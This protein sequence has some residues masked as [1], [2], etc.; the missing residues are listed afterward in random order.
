M[1]DLGAYRRDHADCSGPLMRSWEQLSEV[2]PGSP[3][4]RYF[5]R[6]E[7]ACRHCGECLLDPVALQ[8]LDELRYRA[9]F[10]LRV[11]SGYRCPVHNERVGGAKHS[12]HTKG[13]AFDLWL[14]R[15][16]QRTFVAFLAAR[17]GFTGIGVYR[18]FLHLDVG[19]S[20]FWS[21]TDVGERE[22]GP[23]PPADLEH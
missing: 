6:E 7:L 20:R 18:H 9:G 3:P 1:R 22:P 23:P 2:R 12:Y 15:D 10:P 19:P 5:R 17:V 4:A 16:P 14:P 21:G 8:T 13:Q 11:N